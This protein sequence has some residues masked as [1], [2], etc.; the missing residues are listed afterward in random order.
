MP[1][2]EE[3]R[4]ELVALLKTAIL[5]AVETHP[6]SQEEIDWVRMAIKAEVERAALRKAIIE[7]SLAGLVWMALATGGG[8]MVD[9]FIRHWK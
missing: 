1:L 9:F 5:E 7:K 3:T 2:D 8:Y 4:H 6:L